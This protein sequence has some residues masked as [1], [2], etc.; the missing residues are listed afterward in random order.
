MKDFNIISYLELENNSIDT[1]SSIDCDIDEFES[2]MWT[3]IDTSHN[4]NY[5]YRQKENYLIHTQPIY[6]INPLLL[7]SN[8]YTD[9]TY[10]SSTV[11]RALLTDFFDEDTIE[12]CNIK[13]S[14]P[15]P[16]PN[17]N[18]GILIDKAQTKENDFICSIKS[19]L[20]RYCSNVLTNY[21]N[22]D[23][24]YFDKVRYQ[25]ISYKFSKTYF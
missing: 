24:D 25:E 16:I 18:N 21:R 20:S 12:S 3:D 4:N 23:Q 10:D 5:N 1:L 2:S 7:E 17:N 14:N 15:K 13:I 19:K 6:M 22:N 11:P 8:S 9:N